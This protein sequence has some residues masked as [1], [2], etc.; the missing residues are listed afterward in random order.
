MYIYTYKGF[1]LRK[2]IDRYNE[3]NGGGGKE[4]RRMILNKENER[5]RGLRLWA[6]PGWTLR[7]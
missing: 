6:D 2:R 4:E 3:F 5:E 7:R 1:W